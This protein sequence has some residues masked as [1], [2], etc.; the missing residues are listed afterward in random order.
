MQ[1][2]KISNWVHYLIFLSL[3]SRKRPSMLM[4]KTCKINGHLGKNNLHTREALTKFSWTLNEL[5]LRPLSDLMSIIVSTV[6][7]RIAFPTF[8]LVSVFVATCN[9]KHGA[10]CQKQHSF[11]EASGHKQWWHL[12]L[13]CA[14]MSFIASLES[15]SLLPKIRS[16]LNIRT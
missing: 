10:F 12:F 4:A 7:Y 14:R 6:S 13:T 8:L 15:S 2:V 3:L 11:R 9:R 16:S 1:E 5:T